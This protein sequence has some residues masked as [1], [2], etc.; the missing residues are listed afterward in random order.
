MSPHSNQQM[1]FQSCMQLANEYKG[2]AYECWLMS[3]QCHNNPYGNTPN[4]S[5]DFE[6][7]INR[8]HYYNGLA[9]YYANIAIH[10]PHNNMTMA[11]TN[12]TQYG[13]STTYIQANNSH[14]ADQFMETENWSRRMELVDRGI[15]IT[16][17]GMKSCCDAVNL[18]RS[19]W[20]KR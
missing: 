5:Y 19:I 16:L 14:Y 18:I 7:L 20:P 13:C 11:I 1:I 6:N 17:K 15:N 4:D 8:M 3:L 9:E 2:M 12:N 10:L